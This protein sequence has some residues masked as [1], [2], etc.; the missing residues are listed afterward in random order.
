MSDVKSGVKVQLPSAAA[1]SGAAG[2]FSGAVKEAFYDVGDTMVMPRLLV[3]EV[4]CNNSN[5]GLLSRYWDACPSQE[6]LE[7]GG[8]I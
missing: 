8:L 4:D 7:H 1:P 6:P 5:L 2:H 3:I